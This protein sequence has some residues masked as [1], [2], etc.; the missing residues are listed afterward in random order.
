MIKIFEKLLN[1]LYIKICYFCGSSKDDDF[2]CKKCRSK[3]HYMPPSVLKQIKGVNVYSC[4]LYDGVIRELIL[5]FKYKGKKQ[6]ASVMAE[7]MYNYWSELSISKNEYLVLPVPIHNSRK[8]ERKYNH[9][10][11]AVQEFCNLTK[12]KYNLDFLIRVKDTQKQFSLHKQERAKNIKDAFDINLENMPDKSSQIL[13]LDDITSTGIT[14]EEIIKV[15]HKNGY[16]NI[17]ALT[18]ATPDIWN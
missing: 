2:M 6:F 11:L 5:A 15:L 7:L 9:M 1:L 12:Y 14:L 4:S 13:I 17:T 18:L 3:I 16:K 10:D 8:K